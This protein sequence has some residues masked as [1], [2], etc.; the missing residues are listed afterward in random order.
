MEA[1]TQET[2]T[3]AAWEQLSPL[4]DEAMAHLRDKDRDAI[5]LRYFQN[6]SLRD[7]GAAL[8]VDEYAAQK[9]VARA[10]EKLRAFFV[11]RGIDSTAETVAGAISAN[12]VQAA[13]ALLAKSVA[14]VAAAKGAAASTST[15]TLIKGALKIMAWSKA[16]TAIVVG[17]GILLAAGI[18]S[19]TVKQLTNINVES[20]AEIF[21]KAQDAYASLSS[22]SDEGKTVTVMNGMTLT[23]TFTIKL[24]RPDLYRIEWEQAVTA[25]KGTVWSAGA[26]DFVKLGSR[27]AQ[28]EASKESALSSA[29]GVLGSASA[30]IPGTFFKM[31]W[32]NQLG[33]STANEK[34]QADEKV[35]DV[36][37]YVFT[38]ELKGRTRML[39]IGKKDYLIHQVRTVTSAKAMK[40]AID[41]AAKV[42]GVHPQIAPQSMTSTETHLN[43]VLNKQL[44]PADFQ[45]AQ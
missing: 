42:T 32:G 14:A 40:T 33:G 34:Q 7:V 24:A 43:I 36:D 26:G 1:V 22:Y 3:D 21:K 9:R 45:P 8:G 44:S 6:R 28:K 39:W 30:T 13:P 19:V 11:K 38:S 15:L 20:P 25:N 23:T 29:S 2:Q 18:A 5:V 16:K 31:N 35:G 27:L 10:L 17:V 4:L 12:S 37:C 41:Q